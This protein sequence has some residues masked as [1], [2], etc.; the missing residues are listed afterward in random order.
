MDSSA[1]YALRE[2]QTPSETAILPGILST[3]LLVYQ[4][5]Q[6]RLQVTLRRTRN[7]REPWLATLFGKV[8]KKS[9]QTLSATRL[10]FHALA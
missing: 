9:F 3:I 4:I 2:Q 8:T 1:R 10:A 6:A 7:K 5:S